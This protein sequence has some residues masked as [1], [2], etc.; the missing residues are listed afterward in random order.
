LRAH[1]GATEVQE[2]TAAGG[3]KLVVAGSRAKEVAAF[4]MA[5]A[6]ALG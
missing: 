5:A 6:E 1:G 2:A 4:V 3:N